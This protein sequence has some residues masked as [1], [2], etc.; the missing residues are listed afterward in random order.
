MAKNPYQV[1]GPDFVQNAWALGDRWRERRKEKKIDN[2]MAG[3]FEDPEATIQEVFNID[4]NTGMKLKKLHEEQVNS[5]LEARQNK[6]K[7]QMDTLSRIADYLDAADDDPNVNVNDAY[8]KITPI[9]KGTLGLGDDEIEYYRG[10]VN[11]NPKMLKTLLGKSGDEKPIILGPG[12]QM[13][14][15]QGNLLAEAPFAPRDSK[16][17]A[18]KRGDGGTDLY[19]FDP[20]SGTFVNSGGGGGSPVGTGAA[21]GDFFS[22]LANIESGDR[23]IPSEVDG[24]PA[25]P[26]TRSQG[27][28]QITTP[29]WQEF[30][31][32]A[33][34]DVSTYPN[35]MSA[36]REIQQQVAAV[37]PFK[38]FG[39]RT[40]R[41]MTEKYGPLDRN[42]TIGDLA[43][44]YGGSGPRPVVST[45]GKPGG[46]RARQLSDA[47][48]ARRRLNPE[49]RWQEMPNGETKIIGPANKGGKSA[50]SPKAQGI[51]RAVADDLKFFKEN[52][53]RLKQHRGL[54]RITG[55]TGAFPS[56]PG[57]EAADAQAIFDSLKSQVSLAKLQAM[58]DASATGGALGNVSNYEIKVLE[59]NFA[60]LAQS[61]S[62]KQFKE[63]LGIIERRLDSMLENLYAE[64]D[65]GG[66]GSSPP[67]AAIDLLRSNPSQQMRSFFDQKYGAGA[68]AR[69]LGN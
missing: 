40:Q 2:A 20:E 51:R 61:Q 31:G 22:D 32:K 16:T 48:V 3:W 54:P 52:V 25:G 11:H 27:H 12:S 65:S 64:P 33:G 9:L 37:I 4:R 8:T 68:A 29:T 59:N 58:R 43:A 6:V 50:I 41:L 15:A 62:T 53:K 14:D 21:S 49:Y 66:G 18:I 57:G 36:P 30:A 67:Q 26:G 47:E 13:R 23:N 46:D 10:A 60:A 44:K 1:I 42:A 55:F 5:E 19:V 28:F 56:F 34:V 63:Q 45:P 69:V 24:D 7:L 38:R 39:P 35:A 17:V